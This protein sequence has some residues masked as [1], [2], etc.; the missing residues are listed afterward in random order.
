MGN[1]I[2]TTTIAPTTTIPM[3]TSIPMTMTQL[4]PVQS[5]QQPL[6]QPQQP[7]QLQQ[8]PPPP[9]PETTQPPPPASNDSLIALL[10]PQTLLMSTNPTTIDNIQNA[11]T[12][13]GFKDIKDIKETFDQIVLP[14]NINSNEL[15]NYVNSYNNNM[16][17][18]DDP[19]QLNKVAFDTY[20]HIQ[21]KKINDLQTNLATLQKSMVNNNKFPAQ[22]K[23][24]KSMSNAQMLNIEPYPDPTLANNGQD[25]TYKGNNAKKYPNYLI[26]GN[27]GC[28][29]YT[30][31]PTGSV[32]P[33]WN[34]QSCNSNNPNQQFYTSQI[35]NM[36]QYNAPITNP[37][38]QNYL[39]KDSN[40]S[41][42]GFY[43]V[44]PSVASDQC[45]QLN[46]DGLS[47]MPCNMEAAQRFRP[48]YHSILQ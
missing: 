2:P 38:N 27:N 32:A 47:V 12:I 44:N 35:T 5:L 10:P 22:I 14:Q 18:L 20:I 26:Y 6:Q 46:N 19:N 42:Y 21:D 36:E 37:N 23:G 1:V 25:L 24:L 39:I 13:S 7:Q 40:S 16:S 3:A 4:T 28:L 33:S 45:L 17:L 9:P 8:P 41:Q 11:F 30:P 15:N 43:I 29:Q 31:Q 48:S 34:F